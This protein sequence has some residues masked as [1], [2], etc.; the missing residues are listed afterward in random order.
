MGIAFSTERKSFPKFSAAFGAKQSGFLLLGQCISHPSLRMP[1]RFP[2]HR[3][4]PMAAT[5]LLVKPIFLKQ[6]LM[7]FKMYIT[8]EVLRSFNYLELFCLFLLNFFSQDRQ[9]NK[10]KKYPPIG[11]S[12]RLTK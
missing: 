1:I 11:N 6:I 7:P 3:F 10:A 12:I 2:S 5:N 4:K 8:M 9:V